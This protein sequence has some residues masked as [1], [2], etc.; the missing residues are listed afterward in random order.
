MKKYIYIFLSVF[1]VY[2]IVSCVSAQNYENQ[3][4][5]N[6]WILKRIKK[7]EQDSV[8]QNHEIKNLNEEN[9]N[10]AWENS[11]LKRKQSN[12]YSFD[13]LD[14]TEKEKQSNV[15]FDQL[16]S[17]KKEK[18][19]L[20][21]KNDIQ[22]K[23]ICSLE[24]DNKKLLDENQ[25]LKDKNQQLVKENQR[26]KEEKVSI[27][28]PDNSNY[29]IEKPNESRRIP[30]LGHTF[31]VFIVNTKKNK[32]TFFWENEDNQRFQSFENLKQYTE[33]QGKQL[34]FA[35]NAGMF[36]PEFT[37]QG[38]F[39]EKGNEKTP[40]DLNTGNGNFYLQFG[41]DDKSNGIFLIDRSNNAHIIKAKEY[42]NFRKITQ[43]ATQS[44]PMLIYNGKI[45]PTFT[46]GSANLNIR[47]G[48]GY[49]NPS[50]I[51]F[52]ISNEPVNFYDFASFL[53]DEFHCSEAL[54]LDGA[55]SKMYLP[56][57]KRIDRGGN[58]TG[59]IGIT[60]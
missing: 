51:V 8:R 32:I 23:R 52:V 18:Q 20:E 24:S 58:F 26:L 50:E 12:D 19:E 60:K 57:M 56:E 25:L 10:L 21:S 53:K 5:N 17:I 43:F 34:I 54:Y 13:Q 47:S 48:V 7:L 33:K 38:L 14:S 9:K 27:I 2:F 29:G 46:K 4:N 35:T 59:I 40:I 37:P 42:G 6:K 31:D 15:L 16:D 45:N 55:I 28:P 22:R 11:M 41:K 30:Y 3:I 49:I 1:V 39:V 36:T 44:G